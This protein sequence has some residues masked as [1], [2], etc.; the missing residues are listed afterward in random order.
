VS[1]LLWLLIAGCGT[2]DVS[3]CREDPDEDGLCGDRDP[4]PTDP[5]N[6]PDNDGICAGF[7]ACPMG[8]DGFDADLDGWP[9]ACDDCPD[10]TLND[11]DSD[12]IC[13][14]QDPCTADPQNLCLRSVTLG[15]QVDHYFAESS[16]SLV[17]AD[18]HELANGAF[19]AAGAGVFQPFTLTPGGERVCVELEDGFGDGGVRGFL[20]DD[21]LQKTLATWDFADWEGS[22]RWCGAI[23]GGDPTGDALAEQPEAWTQ[24]IPACAITVTVVAG[25]FVEEM[26]FSLT[27]GRDRTPLLVAPGELV[28]PG[29]T[30]T[31]DVSVTEGA[32]S[33]DLA[34]SAGDGWSRS[35]FEVRLGAQVLAFGT[36]P[37]GSG[38]R[39]PLVVDCP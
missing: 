32:W 37:S 6:D 14:V 21:L 4:C 11:A 5:G 27:D 36:L 35:T 7:D 22:G 19:S 8:P 24:G 1:V 33:F 12:G 28:E 25:A 38:Q 10:D 31:A 9:D 30:H 3:A 13:D 15:L 34:D 17:E 23:T 29:Q 39:V 2:P 26:G 18:G 20:W 16:W